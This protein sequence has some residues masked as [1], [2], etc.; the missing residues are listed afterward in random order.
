MIIASA[1]SESVV[2]ESNVDDSASFG[3]AV[4]SAD[5]VAIAPGGGVDSATNATCDWLHSGYRSSIFNAGNT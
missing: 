1:R 4:A 5:G 3:A 2:V